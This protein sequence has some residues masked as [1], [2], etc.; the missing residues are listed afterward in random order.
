[1]NTWP[2]PSA[3]TPAEVATTNGLLGR[4]DGLAPTGAEPL[5]APV[6]LERLEAYWN[7]IHVISWGEGFDLGRP[8][9]RE[10]ARQW[11]IKFLSEIGV[12][13]DDL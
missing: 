5:S 1:M 6:V 13:E 7:R 3:A 9:G 12:I 4:P 2:E 8:D 11:V 10:H